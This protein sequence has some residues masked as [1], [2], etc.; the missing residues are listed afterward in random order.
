M[1]LE[2]LLRLL[3][4]RQIRPKIDQFVGLAGVKAAHKDLQTGGS[5]SGA[6]ICEPWKEDEIFDTYLKESRD[7][8]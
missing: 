6:I 8:L 3:A 7:A 5:L 2:F 1:D 4:L